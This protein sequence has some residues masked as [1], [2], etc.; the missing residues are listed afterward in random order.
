MTHFIQRG[1]KIWI[2]VFPDKPV[3]QRPPE[4]TMGGGKGAVDHYVVPVKP[5]RVLFEMDGVSRKVA[6]EALRLAS[7]KLPI[8]TK[9]IAREL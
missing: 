7:H 3:T 6:E 1:G 5:G 9:F 8:K 2:R 4:V